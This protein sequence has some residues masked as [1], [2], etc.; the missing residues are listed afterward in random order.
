MENASHATIQVFGI[1]TIKNVKAVLRHTSTTKIAEDAYVQTICR[2]IL[3]SSA[4]NVSSQVTG[5]LIKEDAF[6]VLT[7]K[8]TTESEEFVLPAPRQLHSSRITN[9]TVVHKT[10]ITT[11]PE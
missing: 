4:F 11:R 8:F 9:V 6:S 1:M 3:V 7:N 10:H 2:L 5:T